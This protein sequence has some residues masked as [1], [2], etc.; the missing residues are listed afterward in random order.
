MQMFKFLDRSY[1]P[2]IGLF[3][4]LLLPLVVLVGIAGTMRSWLVLQEESR[5]ARLRAAEYI[6][7]L[8]GAY[9]PLLAV[10]SSDGRAADI[11]GVLNELAKQPW[12]AGIRWEAADTAQAP[13]SVAMDSTVRTPDVPGWIRSLSEIRMVERSGS[14]SYRGQIVGTLTLRTNPAPFVVQAWRRTRDQMLMVAAVIAALFLVSF[15][16]TRSSLRALRALDDA[17]GRLPDDLDLRVPVAGPAEIRDLGRAF[18]LMADRLSGA[19]NDLRQEREQLSIRNERLQV[20]LMSISDGVIVTDATGN[21][22]MLNPVAERMTDWT[23]GQAAGRPIAEVFRIV[24]EDTRLPVEN[25]V[26][27]AITEEAVVGMANHTVLISRNGEERAIKDSA[28][29]IRGP[30]GRVSGAIMVFHDVSD[31]MRLMQRMDWQATHDALTGL[32]NRPLL[33]DRLNQ[34]MAQAERSGQLVAV[35]FL[36]IDHFKAINDTHGHEAGDCLLQEISRRMLAALRGVD[37][38]ARLGGDEFVLLLCGLSGREEAM[39]TLARVHACFNDPIPAGGD[40]RLVI[41]PSIGVAYYE[42][43]SRIGADVLLRH[44]DVA[45]YQAKQTGRNG[46]REY[47]AASETAAHERHLLVQ[48]VAQ[49]IRNGELRLHFQPQINMRTGEIVGFEALVRWQHPERGMLPPAEF[50]PLIEETD[51]ISEMGQ[52]VLNETLEQ[53]ARWKVTGQAW[54]VSINLSARCLMQD[55]LIDR[56]RAALPDP[57]LLDLE[58][59]ETAAIRDVGH[60]ARLLDQLRTLGVGTALDDFGTGYASLSYLQHLRTDKI[61]IDKS[62]VGSVLDNPDDLALVTGMIS[63]SNALGRQVVAEGIETP[64]HGAVLMRMGCDIAQGYAIAH[65]MPGDEI[66]DWVRRYSPPSMW[67]DWAQTTWDLDDFPMMVSQYDHMRWVRKVIDLLDGRALDMP[68]EQLASHK[69]CRF[70]QW[71]HGAGFKR[72]G[73]TRAF[74]AIDDIHKKVHETGIRLA[75]LVERGDLDAARQEGERLLSLRD[76]L[77]AQLAALQGSAAGRTVH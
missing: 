73:G 34:A 35:C 46:I 19:M 10:M 23:S 51:L 16:T 50:I 70:G 22:T 13:V 32:P 64:E 11:P 38:I 49:A 55:G 1:P 67:S 72:Y 26:L 40:K 9:G 71:Y 15:L 2:R 31:H 58:I 69:H 44:A 74:A 12:L 27:R 62:F 66:A 45:M 75:S 21:V 43:K 53:Q 14:H 4:R 56:L 5:E 33:M 76:D 47:D 30:D 60:V 68:P 28:A 41:S 61:K 57:G 65:A 59:V 18:N 24:N 3:A 6:D 63:I 54:P 7:R 77:L 39:G 25:P 20:T 48:R 36:D 29:P 37:T 42:P 52:W 8:A 17:A